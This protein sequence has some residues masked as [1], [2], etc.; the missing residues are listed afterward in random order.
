LTIEDLERVMTEEYRQNTQNQQRTLSK[1]GEMLLFQSQVTCYS[2]GKTGHCANECTSGTVNSP[3]SKNYRKFQRK[4]GTCGIRGHTTKDCWTREANKG[5]R[6][7]NWKKPS[8]EKRI[9]LLKR[10]RVL[11]N[12]LSIAGLSKT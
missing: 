3:N 12:L 4:C 5:K 9:F 10:K 11:K 1:K 2:C 6:L 8:E 7:P